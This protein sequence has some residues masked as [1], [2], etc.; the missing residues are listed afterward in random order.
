MEVV[1]RQLRNIFL[2]QQSAGNRGNLKNYAIG[3][4][5]LLCA[6]GRRKLR[7]HDLSFCYCNGKN[8]TLH[9]RQHQRAN[10]GMQR[11]YT[12]LQHIGCK[13]C[14]FLSV[15][16]ASRSYASK[17]IYADG[18]LGDSGGRQHL[19]QWQH[20]SSGGEQLRKQRKFQPEHHGRSSTYFNR[21][22]LRTLICLLRSQESNLQCKQPDRMHFRM[23]CTGRLHHYLGCKHKL[24]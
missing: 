8:S 19:Q 18:H 4:H 9:S 6:F 5:Y 21:Q 1:Q 24:H 20:Q 11:Q 12:D 23:D 7:N 16:L 14:H 10:F 22:H 3:N 17:R 2:L 13:R 15:D